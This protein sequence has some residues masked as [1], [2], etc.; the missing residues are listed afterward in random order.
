MDNQQPSNKEIFF[1]TP[2]KG[3]GFIYKYTSP[4]NHSYIGQTIHSLNQRA[5]T[6]YNGIGYKKCKV[7]WSAIQKHGWNSFTVEILEEVPV[8]QLNEREEYYINYYNT[9]VPNGYNICTTAECGKKQEV[10]VYS[11]QNGKLLEHYNSVT[12]AAE[13]TGVPIETISAILNNDGQKKK[14][15]RVAHNLT[16]TKSYVEQINV[17]H[18]PRKGTNVLVY[19]NKG[20]FIRECCSV[21]EASRQTGITTYIISRM[22]RGEETRCRKYIFVEGSTTKSE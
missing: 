20:N 11:I 19:D 21:K 17:S 1:K 9:V 22:L 16:F 12:E 7:F 5:R 3:H 2:Q 18:S 13:E 4:S 6:A 15:R 10:Y 14:N 8:S